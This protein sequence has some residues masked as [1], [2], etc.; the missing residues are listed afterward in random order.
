MAGEKPS[1]SDST[2][3]SSKSPRKTK[4]RRAGVPAETLEPRRVLHGPELGPLAD[5]TV[6]NGAPLH[7]ALD[8]FDDEGQ[9]VHYEVS[10]DNSNLE[11]VMSSSTNRYWQ[12]EVAGFGTMTFQLFEDLAPRTTARIIELT[13]E[14]FYNGL[15][16]HRVINNFM[17]QGGDPLGTGTGGSDLGNF[18]DEFNLDLQHTSSGLLSFAKSGDDTNNSQF[19]ITD[20]PTRHLD[21]N[22]SI[23]GFL[24]SGDSVRDAINSTPTSTGD[25]PVNKVVITSARIIENH[26]DGVL[27]LKA[28]ASSGTANVTVRAI[29]SAG[30]TTTRTFKVT[31]Q[32]DTAN[33]PPFIGNVA[34]PIVI[35]PDRQT[36]TVDIPIFDA[37]GDKPNLLIISGDP[38]QVKVEVDST[39]PA[40]NGQRATARVT[41]TA[42]NNTVGG[43]FELFVNAQQLQ[44]GSQSNSDLQRIPLI[45]APLG[46]KLTLVGEDTGAAGDGVT[47]DT[48][49]EFELTDVLE[50]AEITLYD[51]DTVIGTFTAGKD[52][53][54]EYNESTTQRITVTAPLSEGP[55]VF[56]VTQRTRKDAIVNYKD[57]TTP[58]SP[59]SNAVSAWV[60]TN[61]PLL[62]APSGSQFV[63]PGVPF[64]TDL[65][66]DREGV[67]GT[68]YSLVKSPIGM[69]VNASTGVIQ[70]TPLTQAFGTETVTVRVTDGAG[71]A[72][73]R[74]FDL[75]VNRAPTFD[76]ITRPAIG[77]GAAESF[78]ITAN[79]PDVA[80]GDV[81][82]YTLTGVVPEGAV[83]D[84][85]TGVF[86][87]TPSER[88]GGVTHTFNVR[89]VDQAGAEATTSF[90]IRVDETNVAPIFQPVGDQFVSA[91]ATVS[92]NIVAED[93]D[94]PI[95]TVTYSLK[96][97]SPAGATI[98]AQ[99]GAFRFVV[100]T[101]PGVL[102]YPVTVVADDG[103]G[104][105]TE[106]SFVIAVNVAP[107]FPTLDDQAASEGAT[108][109][110]V[111]AA[112]DAN[113]IDVLTYSLDE[114]PAGATIDPATGRITWSPT[115]SDGGTSVRFTVRATDRGQLQTTASFLVNVAEV[116]DPPT[117]EGVESLYR[118]RLGDEFSLQ[119][120]AADPDLPASSIT[121]SLIDPPE[122]ASIDPVTGRFTYT[123]PSGAAAERLTIRVRAEENDGL[124]VETTFALVVNAEPQLEEIADD[125]VD[126]RETIVITL[127]ASDANLAH[128]DEEL[129]FSLDL[130]PEGMT[131]DPST[132][133]IEW[134]P[135]EAQ[136][137]G[138]Y[139]VQ[140]RVTDLGGLAAG[141]TFHI[142]VHE[143]PNAPELEGI[144]NQ[145]IGEGDT[146]ALHLHGSDADPDGAQLAYSL[147]SGPAGAT[148]DPQ[149]GELEWTPGEADG[150]AAHEFTVRVTDATGLTADQT[151]SV[152]VA[153]VNVAPQLADFAAQ[154]L[155]EGELLS[156][157]AAA[158][159]ADLP[160]GA[161]TY[162]LS[163]AP[164]GMT[165]D[166]AT[167]QIRWTPNA[168]QGGRS[169]DVAVTVTDAAGASD[170]KTL[171]VNVLDSARP[172][173]IISPGT[174]VLAAGQALA[175]QIEFIDPNDGTAG[176]PVFS[177]IEAPEGALL[178]PVTGFLSFAP[179]I[180]TPVGPITFTLA[181]Q[182]G[183]ADG[184]LAVESFIVQVGGLDALPALADA[185]ED[186]DS[187]L[188]GTTPSGPLSTIE[189]LQRGATPAALNFLPTAASGSSV[190]AGAPR[191]TRF[192]YQVDSNV[193]LIHRP[194]ADDQGANQSNSGDGQPVGAT[195]ERRDANDRA[196]RDQDQSP[197]GARSAPSNVRQ[198]SRQV[199]PE[200]PNP[201]TASH[202]AARDQ[203][204]GEFDRVSDLKPASNRL[205]WYTSTNTTV[206]RPV[207][208]WTAE[209]GQVKAATGQFL[210]AE[211]I[212]EVP[213]APAQPM[214]P[215]SVG[216]A[217]AKGA[218]TPVESARDQA[219]EQSAAEAP[220]PRKSAVPS[221]AAVAASAALFMPMLVSELR[222]RQAEDKGWRRWLGGR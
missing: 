162:S 61:A 217:Y 72:T 138:D 175:H 49:L 27:R 12:I 96:S 198:T 122:G 120:A 8:A 90:T 212:V 180:D 159:D 169:Y 167:G 107:E 48:T 133:R 108:F 148:I 73:E 63:A 121:Y 47:K 171:K 87:W 21:F 43:I 54:L 219:V 165:I 29:D 99:T 207:L 216:E 83:I 70:W 197:L 57:V 204:V 62:E 106:L 155:R 172:V 100:P 66:S 193:N 154:K 184:P 102:E 158:T 118:V 144:D 152:D 177:L 20:V 33:A 53:D 173:Q 71:N 128:G 97:G 37:E 45:V 11:T 126:E 208:V 200:Q 119:M 164:E 103:K 65:G 141:R 192:D 188:P 139:E 215:V 15:S 6:G 93:A 9:N 23:F 222:D 40:M 140:V 116:D 147:V 4:R 213:G 109:E 13:N 168:R 17:I 112:T 2:P 52:A 156:L 151:F 39:T 77:E 174:I 31:L 185:Y 190:V 86:S 142:H 127:D 92:L 131:I 160:A 55:H 81:L 161:L 137:E 80:V 19:F 183:G 94:I 98:N 191:F 146:L 125:E 51:N 134:T 179:G 205:S 186:L 79:D 101:E 58:V 113:T 42:I 166:P 26:E 68:V 196:E 123:P 199:T 35:G 25:K 1:R 115:E 130:A 76:T 163:S 181:V 95:N 214:R 111:A 64:T 75:R 150:G 104:G 24:V 3:S 220:A 89:V 7:I 22:H 157:S 110:F 170:T 129:T 41:M 85:Q 202:E 36:V 88:Q 195:S 153:E 44:G 10:S 38:S 143:V 34:A 14:G 218:P 211:Q 91:G 206:P 194:Q 32:A 74:S 18:D 145:A 46:P 56:T 187:F 189:L 210:A 67:P 82:S 124:G 105:R 132:G 84:A 114:G 178:D 5:V 50:L 149:T 221:K 16:F 136:G 69:V 203:V 59:R 135:S 30:D 182:I 117:F 60:Y 209:R 28:N 201:K 176:D 78:H